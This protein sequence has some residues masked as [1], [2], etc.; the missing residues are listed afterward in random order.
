[1]AA[2]TGFAILGEPLGWNHA[3][4]GAVIMAGVILTR[5][6][7]PRRPVLLHPG[8]RFGH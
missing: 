4:G 5:M 6:R 2:L 7:R 3:I 8:R 1:V